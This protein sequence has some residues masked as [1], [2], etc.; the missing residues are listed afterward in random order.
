MVADQVAAIEHVREQVR[1]LCEPMREVGTEG[2][3][4]VGV[5]LLILG[6]AID[7]LA[8]AVLALLARGQGPLDRADPVS[9]T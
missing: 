8:V 7:A 1:I 5:R 4:D 2:R 3:S 9:N 6:D